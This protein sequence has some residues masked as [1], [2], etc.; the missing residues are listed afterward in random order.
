M[1]RKHR[2]QIALYERQTR[3]DHRKVVSL[4]YLQQN[5]AFAHM[6]M[7]VESKWVCMLIENILKNTPR[8]VL[9]AM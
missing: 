3:Q 8:N 6:C 4:R 1:L 2:E 9:P 7:Y 5:R